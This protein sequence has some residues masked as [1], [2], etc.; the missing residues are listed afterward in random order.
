[1][2]EKSSCDDNKKIVE[3]M[4][5]RR[6]ATSWRTQVRSHVCD[7][8][9]SSII[10]SHAVNPTGYRIDPQRLRDINGLIGTLM[11]H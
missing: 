7:A 10:C 2:E 6:P 3:K 1:M 11:I 9:A 5:K 4:Q 8:S